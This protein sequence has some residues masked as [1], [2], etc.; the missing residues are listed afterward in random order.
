MPV[1]EYAADASRN[2]FV[3]KFEDAP[4]AADVLNLF[5]FTLSLA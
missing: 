4:K 1:D 2:A 3:K 5:G